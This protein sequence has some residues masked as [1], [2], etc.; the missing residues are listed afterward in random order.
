MIPRIFGPWAR[1]ESVAALVLKHNYAAA[2]LSHVMCR[3]LVSV[4]WRGFLYDCAFNQQL[5]LG[6]PGARRLH[7]RDLLAEDLEGCRINVADHCYGC[8]AGQGSSCSGAL[9]HDADSSRRSH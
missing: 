4:D 3:T 2:N 6:L 7:L 9:R 5:G 1:T 8:T